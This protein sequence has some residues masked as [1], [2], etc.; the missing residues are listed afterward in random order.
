MNPLTMLL[1]KI[2]CFLKQEKQKEAISMFNKIL[3]RDSS[4]NHLKVFLF[5]I[6][7]Y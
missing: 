4:Y 6:I 5:Y 1:M 2:I 3:E 7:Y